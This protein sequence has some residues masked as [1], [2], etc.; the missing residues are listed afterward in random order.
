[1]T[2]HRRLQ[3]L[4]GHTRREIQFRIQRIKSEMIMMRAVPARWARTA[5]TNLPEIIHAL[6][7][8]RALGFIPT[9]H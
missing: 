3:L 8:A 4:T 5:I 1:M 6:L 9:G 7:R 2:F